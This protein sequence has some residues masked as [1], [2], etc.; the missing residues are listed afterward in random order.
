[1]TAADL[2]AQAEMYAALFQTVA[3]LVLDSKSPAESVAAKPL[4]ELHPEWAN[5]DAFV[6]AAHR[7]YRTHIRRDPRL[8]AV[9]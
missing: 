2:R 8:P 7:S 1:M 9:P 5:A 6:E 4:A 3:G